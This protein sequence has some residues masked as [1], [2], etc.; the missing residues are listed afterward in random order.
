MIHNREKF[1]ECLWN[2]DI[3][4]GCFGSSRIRPSD[5]DGLVEV[6]GRFLLLEAK[7]PGVALNGGQSITFTSMAR[8]N[9][10]TVVVIWGDTDSPTH[11]SIRCGAALVPKY[12]AGVDELRR[13]T[14]EWYEWAMRQV[15]A[16]AQ[17]VPFTPSGLEAIVPAR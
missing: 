8:S 10:F 17:C 15:P 16:C 6:H 4:A 13:I 12:E 3:L 11:L 14:S 1:M 7:S 5:V 2:W 9:L